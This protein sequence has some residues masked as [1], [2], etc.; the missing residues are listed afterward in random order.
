MV[1]LFK[2]GYELTNEDRNV[3][4]ATSSK[5]HERE[6]TLY[7]LANKLEG[8]EYVDSRAYNILCKWEIKELNSEF[9]FAIKDT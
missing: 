7:E 6:L 4:K 1:G 2:R 8:R 5:N 3:V 9:Q